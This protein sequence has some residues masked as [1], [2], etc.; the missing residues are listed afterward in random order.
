MRKGV[1]L[2]H[3]AVNEGALLNAIVKGGHATLHAL[4]AALHAAVAGNL[5]PLVALLPS[6]IP[7]ARQPAWLSA[8][9]S[10]TIYLVTS[11]EDGDF[12]WKRWDSR[13]QRKAAVSDDLGRLGDAAFAPFDRHVGS[14]YGEARICIPWPTS[15]H[16]QVPLPLPDVPA[17]LLV[18]GDDDLAPLE[19]A[20]EIAEQ[21]PEARI[22]TVAGAG[23]GVLGTG[24]PA[25]DALHAF[26]ASTS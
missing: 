11:C 20:R 3:H 8:G 25:A 17:L 13:A 7:D 10:H 6:D 21:L 4:P 15:G 5:A 14:Q 2:G 16:R 1:L 9:S 22:V 24:G 12:P 23:H 19:G 26:A 18:G